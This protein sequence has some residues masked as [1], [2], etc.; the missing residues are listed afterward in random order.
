MENKLFH[1]LAGTAHAQAAQFPVCSWW[2]A[3]LAG[4]VAGQVAGAADW[5]LRTPALSDPSAFPFCL[6]ATLCSIR[7]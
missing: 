3:N 1:R 5:G 7:I 4:Q 6:S 2:G